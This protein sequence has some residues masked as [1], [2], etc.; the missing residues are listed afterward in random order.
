MSYYT[1]PSGD[2]VEIFGHGGGQAEARRQQTTFLGEIPI[3]TEIREGGDRGLP[4]VVSAPGSAPGLAFLRI[5][6][7][8]RGQLG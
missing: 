2:R 3:F 5:A 7:T 6:E 4:V 1:T 8:L